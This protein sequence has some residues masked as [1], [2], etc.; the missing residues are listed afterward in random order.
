MHRV[1]CCPHS[2]EPPGFRALST[3]KWRM[4]SALIAFTVLSFASAKESRLDDV[5][6]GL[7][8]AILF[9][10]N[11][12]E[13]FTL[14]GVLGFRMLQA[15]LEDA[16]KRWSLSG[17]EA[18]SQFKKVGD[19]VRRLDF[20]AAKAIETVK[21]TDPAY[22]NA[23]QPTLHIDFWTLDP[24]WIKTDAKLVY[25]EVRVT[26]CFGENISDRCMTQLLGTWK[27][28]GVSCL[29]SDLCKRMMTTLNCQGYSLSHQLL[30]FIIV[31]HKKCSNI[32]HAQHMDSRASLFVQGYKKIF[33]SNMLQMNLLIEKNGYPLSEQDLFLEY[34]ML[35][36]QAGFSEF[37]KAEWLDHILAW[38][39]PA[40]CF[41][42]SGQK[43]T[44]PKHKRVKRRSTNLKGGCSDHMTAVA[45]GALGGYLRFY[46]TS[47]ILQEPQQ[48][49]NKTLLHL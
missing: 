31:E 46:A 19:L 16:L 32:V 26:E 25:P 5:I 14:D 41:G 47:R 9:F 7:G 27:N 45:V 43:Y 39:L 3:P 15:E 42:K 37:F 20:I 17:H 2:S 29:E 6:S 1:T 10:E 38:Q 11:E 23:F 48:L 12:Y 21:V 44:L 40:G 49:S 33:C 28:Y 22:F 13:H 35:C 24:Q 18:A 30:Y 8:K 34:V 36:G 4:N